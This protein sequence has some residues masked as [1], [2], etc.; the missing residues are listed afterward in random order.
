MFDLLATF[1]LYV[2]IVM[3][4]SNTR[5]LHERPSA[6]FVLRLYT[7]LGIPHRF[8]RECFIAPTIHLSATTLCTRQSTGCA[9]FHISYPKCARCVLRVLSSIQFSMSSSLERI[10]HLWL[11]VPRPLENG[12]NNTRASSSVHNIFH[13]TTMTLIHILPMRN[14]NKSRPSK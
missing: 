4:Q 13:R 8:Q 14:Q 2:K 9:L 10:P 11:R 7:P 3:D 6:G 5:A 1:P 12:A